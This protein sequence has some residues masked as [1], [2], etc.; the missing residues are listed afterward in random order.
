MLKLIMKKTLQIIPFVFFALAFFL[1]IQVFVAIKNNKIPSVFGY[2]LASVLSDSM[3]PTF[4]KGDLIYITTNFDVSELRAAS[5][6]YEGDVI[7]FHMPLQTTSGEVII[8]NSHRIVEIVEV[9]GSYTFYTKGDNNSATD[10]Y[11]V[12][13]DDLLGVWTGKVIDNTSVVA[14]IYQFVSNGGTNLI[15]AIIIIIF[16]LIGVSEA[17]N[18]I[19]QVSEQK[20]LD[21]EKEKEELIEKEKAR[22]IDEYNKENNK[23][24]KS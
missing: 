16:A 4:T 12:T 8:V 21:L 2:S 24:E 9:N 13:E 11:V 1:V 10:D 5:D 3:D 7:T 23:V 14:Q 19:K 6:T 22:L 18:I 15:Y 20:K 17:I